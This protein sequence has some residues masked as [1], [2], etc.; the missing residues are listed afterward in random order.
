[1]FIYQRKCYLERVTVDGCFCCGVGLPEE[2]LPNSQTTGSSCGGVCLDK[3]LCRCVRRF[4]IVQT[5]PAEGYKE[6]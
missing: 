1:M 5:L 3:N 6:L 4:R 2:T